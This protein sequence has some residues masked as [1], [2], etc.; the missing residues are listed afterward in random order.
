MK[1][2]L[3]RTGLVVFLIAVS[4]GFTAAR[5]PGYELSLVV[6]IVTGERSRDSN[7]TTATLTLNSSK[8]T[9]QQSY[10][11]AHS[12]GRTPVKKEYTLTPADLNEL[13]KLIR[14][15]NLLT[16]RRLASLS[17]DDGPGSYFSLLIRS[18]LNSKEHTITIDLPR[19]ATRLKSDPLYRDA[20]AFVEYL[21]RVIERTDPDISMPELIH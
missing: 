14:G 13:S 12:G 1:S 5:A 3:F 10:H 16:T 6:T 17:P 9:Y 7:S 2:T 15:K 19:N 11:G 21:Y 18:R 20:V 4:A 8:L